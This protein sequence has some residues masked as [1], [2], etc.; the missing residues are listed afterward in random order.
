MKRFVDNLKTVALIVTFILVPILAIWA[1][2]YVWRLKHPD[3]PTW[4]FF[5]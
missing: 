1:K 3:A 2:Y 5:F 4:T